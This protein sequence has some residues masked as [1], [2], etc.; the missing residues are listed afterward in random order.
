MSDLTM[1]ALFTVL[2][3]DDPERLLAVHETDGDWML[4]QH[5]GVFVRAQ[6][7]QTVHDVQPFIPEG[8][9]VD[10]IVV[11]PEVDEAV[12][13]D[14]GAW[15]IDGRRW[16]NDLPKLRFQRDEHTHC[17]AVFSAAIAAQEA[18]EARA[19]E[20]TPD[21]LAQARERLVN[22]VDLDNEALSGAAQEFVAALA[23][24]EGGGDRG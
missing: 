3:G 2:V 16:T 24:T 4:W 6:H 13:Q 12:R 7:W 14:D 10:R 11:V 20:P 17:V 15:L 19:A 23:A 8:T 21:P 5:P 9:P 1:P 22:S 18:Y